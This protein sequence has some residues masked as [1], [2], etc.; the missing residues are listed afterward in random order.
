MRE[1]TK[2]RL[3]ALCMIATL[4]ACAVGP[5]YRPKP[6]PPADF[7]AVPLDTYVQES[8]ARQFWTVFGDATL[9]DLIAQALRGNQDLHVAVA[10]LNEARALR[11]EA[12][13][14]Y[15]PT[16][17]ANAAQTAA[18]QSS[19]QLFG[20]PLADRK[21]NLSSAGFDAYWELDFFGRVRRENESAKA[22]EDALRAD[23]GDAQNT[24]AAEVAR[25]YFE[26]RGAQLRLAV[27]TRN[28]DNQAQTLAYTQ[29]R[30]DAGR[31]TEFDTERAKAQ[32][33][34]TRAI[35]PSLQMQIAVSEHRIAVL[36]GQEPTA[37]RA[38]LDPTVEL[39]ALPHLVAIGAPSDLLRRRPDVRAAERR[40]AA[41]TAN[42]GVITADYF[43]R[44]TFSG[45]VGFAVHSLS[46]VGKSGSEY[47][48][49][50]PSLTWAAFDLGRVHARVKQ[51]RAQADEATATYEKTV[52]IALEE[53]QN[54]L[55]SYTKGRERMA[56]L[57]S[58]RQASE[59]AAQL[60]RL[61]Y[62]EGASDFLDELDA[63]R[64]QLTAEDQFADAQTSV[65]TSLVALYKALDGG[66]LPDPAKDDRL[67][68]AP[69]PLQ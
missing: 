50:G 42:V 5:N 15:A 60:A 19:D 36:T 58:S 20:L 8:P 45:E 61:R 53:T 30:L 7:S 13:F 10:R 44:V 14:D 66:W 28:S 69:A 40:L 3:A 11:Q 47:Y 48:Q 57:D 18:L 24:V 39:P 68:A 51:S 32:L 2:Y 16:V 4:A 33:D 52:L 56:L 38:L 64:N 62:Q 6:P 22:N 21:T 29:A 37:L 55:V 31:S 49:F 54:A 25:A 27:A 41:A 23:L 17:T 67:A 65:A 35:V 59:N 9:S 34:A 1:T 63:E 12:L 26:L 43:P 46:A